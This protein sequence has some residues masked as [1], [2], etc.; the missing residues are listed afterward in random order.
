LAVNQEADAK[1]WSLLLDA[2]NEKLAEYYGKFGF[3]AM[4]PT[5]RM[6]D[7]SQR[8]RMWRPAGGP[9]GRA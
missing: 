9:E 5:V 3:C 7:G 6:P 2:S 8:V 1:G 4:G